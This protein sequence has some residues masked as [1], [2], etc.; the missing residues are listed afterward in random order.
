MLTKAFVPYGGG[1]GLQG[2]QESN[3]KSKISGW[4]LQVSAFNR[5]VNVIF[6]QSVTGSSH[7]GQDM[8]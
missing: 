3:Q 7:N 8:R 6:P 2:Q 4:S 1:N 5:Q